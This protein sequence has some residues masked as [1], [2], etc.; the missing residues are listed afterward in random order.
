MIKHHLPARHH[1]FP[2]DYYLIPGLIDLHVHGANGK[3]VMDGTEEA[4]QAISVALAQ[5][6]VTG[7]LATTMTADVERIEAALQVIPKVIEKPEGAAIL[8]VHLEGPFI[9]KEKMGAQ[10]GDHVRSPDVSLFQKWQ[11]L[12][13][14]SIKLVTLA[15]ELPHADEFI[16][17]LRGMNVI[18]SIGH[19][20][21]T[22]GETV[23]AIAAGCTQATHLF[24]AMSGL[25]Q[26]HPGA[27][28]ALLLADDV[29]AE[30]ITDGMHLHPAIVEI[31]WQMK[32]KDKL[33]LVTDAMRGKCL[34]DGDFDLGGQ[35]VHVKHGRAALPDGTLA[36]STLRM[37]DA[38][39]N[40]MKFS[41]C[42]LID[43]IHL[44]TVNPVHVLGLSGTKGDISVG[45]DADLVVCDHEFVVKETMRC[46]KVIFG[47]SN[48]QQTLNR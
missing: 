27:V 36:G 43:A 7:F 33:F 23:E 35:H 13:G 44:A 38:I 8:G 26:R 47:E 9:S 30:I 42:T 2:A 19:T 22:Y 17:A 40:M 31:A 45:K 1:H 14:D 37:P 15:P 3:D 10:H 41:H 32:G 34:G 16:K 25:H 28:G 29:Y 46:G 12:S 21:A 11:S 20:N 4:M 39:K 5:E 18:A 48:C 6:G 24:N